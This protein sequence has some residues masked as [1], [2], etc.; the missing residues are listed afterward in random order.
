MEGVAMALK[1][2]Q[3]PGAWCA[4][5]YMVAERTDGKWCATALFKRGDDNTSITIDSELATWAEA[6]EACENA[7][8][9]IV[10]ALREIGQ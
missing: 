3:H 10:H 4:G 2:V 7:H 6:V 9:N 5:P 8:K 1:W